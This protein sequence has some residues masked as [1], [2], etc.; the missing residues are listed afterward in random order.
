VKAYYDRGIAYG[1][2]K[3]YDRAITDFNK[4]IE[5]DPKYA[6]AYVG[7]AAGYA[8]KSDRDRAIADYRKSL[9]LDPNNTFASGDQPVNVGLPLPLL[10]YAAENHESPSQ[11]EGILWIELDRRAEVA[12]RIF[13]LAVVSIC[14]APNCI[15]HGKCGVP[16]N[17]VGTGPY[18]DVHRMPRLAI[19]RR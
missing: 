8:N 11:R 6:A 10:A 14:I 15:G 3:D 7:R 17:D 2:K 1:N 4:A 19:G 9:E 16:R 13:P 18:C 12:E 5:L